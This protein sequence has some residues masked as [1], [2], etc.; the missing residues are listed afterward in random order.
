VFGVFTDY[1]KVRGVA[2]DPT[3]RRSSRPSQL[4]RKYQSGRQQ[5]KRSEVALQEV[6]EATRCSRVQKNAPPTISWQGLAP[7]T[8]LSPPPNWD[9]GFEFS[10][11]ARRCRLQRIFFPLPT[12]PVLIFARKHD[13]AEDVGWYGDSHTGA[14]R[15]SCQGVA[16]LR[17]G[18]SSAGG[19][20]GPTPERRGQASHLHLRAGDRKS[21][22]EGRAR[23]NHPD[24]R[25]PVWS[26]ILSAG[27]NKTH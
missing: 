7:R 8:R 15:I 13:P 6:G 11:A 20:L 26:P 12:F 16:D 5:G 14:A 22:R 23:K 24:R 4:A 18:D 17:G 9:P 10:A 27:H 19:K 25:G 3:E 21:N 2:R 1:Y